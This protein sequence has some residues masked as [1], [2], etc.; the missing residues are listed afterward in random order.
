[1]AHEHPYHWTV[2]RILE[3]KVKELEIKIKELEQDVQNL[4]E[5]HLYSG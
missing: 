5:E 4:K 3:R 2:I 1:M